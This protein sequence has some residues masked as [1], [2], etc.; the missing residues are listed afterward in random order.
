MEKLLI[1][2]LLAGTFF[3]I[4]GFILYKFPPKKINGFYGYRTKTSM[5]NQE[6]WDFSQNY[7]ANEMMKFGALLTASSSIGLILNFEEITLLF[8]GVGL[9][10]SLLVIMIIRI[11]MAIRKKIPKDLI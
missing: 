2:P 10:I 6:I 5:N 3:M 11:E 1:V 8:M 4:L 9:M 7:S